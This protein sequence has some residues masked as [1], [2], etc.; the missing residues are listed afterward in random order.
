MTLINLVLVCA[1]V[2]V[3]IAAL[4]TTIVSE[5]KRK[6]SNT[7]QSNQTTY[8]NSTENEVKTEH[9]TSTEVTL[10]KTDIVIAAQKTLIASNNGTL[11]PGKYSI[12]SAESDVD[13][14]NVRIGK[15]VKEYKH[16]DVVVIAEGEEVTPTSHKIILR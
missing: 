3:F 1:I 13:S 5:V 11:R 12:L 15:F 9:I 2:G 6:K 10:E 14:F 7:K 16:G 4:I 8:N